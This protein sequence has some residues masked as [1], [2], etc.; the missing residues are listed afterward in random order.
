MPAP[1]P[2]PFV[3][4][5]RGVDV[6]TI[7][8]GT[9]EVE[10]EETEEVVADA[11]AAGYRHIDTAAA[12]ANERQVGHGIKRS[13]LDPSEIWVTTKVWLEDYAPDRVRNSA[14][15]SLYLLGLDRIDLLLLHWPPEDESLM[16]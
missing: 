8:I 12:Y 3:K 2:A 5:V 16:E 10:P 7:G 13:G 4:T 11:L 6:P 9:F 1:V 14:E 15:R